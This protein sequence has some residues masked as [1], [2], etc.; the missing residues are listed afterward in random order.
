MS[1]VAKIEQDDDWYKN[2][3]KIFT[4]DIVDALDVALNVD[5]Y[6]LSWTLEELHDGESDLILKTSS[7]GGITTGPGASTEDRVSIA[8][9]AADTANLE[10]RVYQQSLWRTDTG[11]RQLLAQ[12][13]AMLQRAA[14]QGEGS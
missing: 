10:P 14:T 8:I 9:D 1:K 7:G 5:G 3:D 11:V 6:I 2:E 4:V 12:G 13:S